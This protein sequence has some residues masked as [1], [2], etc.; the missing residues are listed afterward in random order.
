ML[1]VTGLSVRAGSFLL[2]SLSLEVPPSSCHILLGPTGSGKTLLLESIIGLRNLDKGKILLDGK[3]ITACPA[4]RR[5]LAYVPQDLALFPHLS[6]R[7]NILYP[8]RIRGNKQSAD[9]GIVRELIESLG[10][11]HVLDRPVSNLS[12]GER[13]RTAL[14]RAV[15]SNCKT[16]V[17]D[18]PLSALH[19]SLKREL[20]FLLKDIQK[21]YDLAILMVT[22]NLHEAFFL[23]DTISIL[24]DGKLHQQGVKGTVYRRPNSRA[25]AKFLGITNLFQATAQGI[26]GGSLFVGCAEL[27]IT[28][29]LSGLSGRSAETQAPFSLVGIRSEDVHVLIPG[30]SF[31]LTTNIVSATIRDVYE[32]GSSLMVTALCGPYSTSLEAVVPGSLSRKFSFS[33]GQSVN[34]HLPEEHLFLIHSGTLQ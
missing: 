12:G 1:E 13:Q 6:V 28:L 24:I 33:K 31:S 11:R 8:L 26:A 30:G 17:L 21:R 3:D 2:S 22:H 4:E 29:K 34:F 9:I 14:A 10:I 19:Q 15:A 32:Q 27:G 25:V 16:L 23:G 18:E 5:G 20:W 7:E